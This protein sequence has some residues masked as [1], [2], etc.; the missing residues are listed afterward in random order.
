MDGTIATNVVLSGADA[1]IT[2]SSVS[3]S[4][5][6]Q[7]S[8]QDTATLTSTT[9]QATTTSATGVG[10]I[11]AFNTIGWDAGN[12]LTKTL[13]ALLG[14]NIGTEDPDLTQASVHAS[15]VDAGGALSVTALSTAHLSS[16]VSNEATAS[17]VALYGAESASYAGVLA[18]NMVATKVLATVD[19]TGAASGTL[20]QAGA[21]VTVS[22][23]DDSS[24][25]AA[26][27]LKDAAQSANSGGTG[28]LTNLINGLLN[29]YQYTSNSGAQTLAF[30]DRVLLDGHYAGGGVGGDVYQY[31][32]TGA[33]VNLG[34]QNYNDYGLWKQLNTSNVVPSSIVKAGLKAL[35]LSTGGSTGMSGLVD[36][37]DLRGEVTASL[38]AVSLNA[39]SGDVL[40]Q[41]LENAVISAA[42]DSVL[43]GGTAEG[44]VVVTNLVLSSAKALVKDSEVADSGGNVILDAEDTS[45]ITATAEGKVDGKAKTIGFEVALNTVG[46]QAQDVLSSTVDALI[47]DPLL[48]SVFGGE[49]PV[50]VE[51]SITDS[52][53]SASGDLSL[54]ADSAAAIDATTGNEATSNV[55]ND[56]AIAAKYG[57]NGMAAA[58]LL[59]SSRVSS[60]ANA[61]IDNS[62]AP[63]GTTVSVGGGVTIQVQ[64]LNHIT[65]DSEVVV[66]STST[67]TLQAI[68]TLAGELAPSTYDYTTASGL[69]ALVGGEMSVLG[70][71]STGSGTEGSLY[72][73][74]GPGATVN[75]GAQAYDTD[76]A[77]WKRLSQT[78]ILGAIFPDVGNVTDSN[79]RAYGGLVVY[80]DARGPI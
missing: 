42:D 60:S 74:V 52:G 46:W 10:V 80:N 19:N 62:G 48:A 11:L 75:L 58:A 13:D 44:G 37:N 15:S 9:K 26:T 67:N 38:T 63:S 57:A 22:A 16:T 21:A 12:I 17:A 1:H 73:Y 4:G 32:G 24:I 76:T 65:S 53:V 50:A 29:D 59:A 41:A 47:G 61:F 20:V 27:H 28:I 36:R 23:K 33:S 8:A 69:W 49:Q 34:T 43:S 18:S 30:G 31:M 25:T 77:D 7:V 56:F 14:T 45:T 40:L 66:T 72:Q 55:K 71:H 64:D 35:G 68:N 79:S 3:A 70:A 5:M 51:A 54:T 6:V 39:A 2:D 78:D